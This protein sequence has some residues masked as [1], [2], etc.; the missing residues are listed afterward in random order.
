MRLVRKTQQG[1]LYI[2]IGVGLS[3]L[4]V[5]TIRA[6]REPLLR[7]TSDR[8]GSTF[9]MHI[10]QLGIVTNEEHRL[11]ADGSMKSNFAMKLKENSTI[12]IITGGEA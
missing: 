11:G 1:G 12:K 8:T 3:T 4:L 6:M 10:L 2:D 9:F 5:S 7:G